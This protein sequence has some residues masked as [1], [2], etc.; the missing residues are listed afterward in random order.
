MSV[1]H[2]MKFAFERLKK[3]IAGKENA[4]LLAFSPSPT[5]FSKAFF[6]IVV[7]TQD[8]VLKG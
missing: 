6:L 2:I 1:S 3:N 8:C 7:K 4:G 5:E